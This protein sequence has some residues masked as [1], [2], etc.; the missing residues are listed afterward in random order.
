M[1][2]ATASQAFGR[3]NIAERDGRAILLARRRFGQENIPIQQIRDA[4][5]GSVCATI[6]GKAVST[7]LAGSPECDQQDLADELIDASK[8][9]DQE[10]AQKMV[11]AAIA[12]R[13]AEKNTRPDFSTNP[14]TNLNSVFCQKAPRNQELKGLVQA[15]DPANNPDLFFDP[16]SGATVVKGTQPNTEPF[17]G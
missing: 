15:Q 14:P 11:A 10:T 1:V 16:A 7:L 9:F 17:Q 12:F 4:C 8:D 13:Q 3:C 6:A 2:V 5:S